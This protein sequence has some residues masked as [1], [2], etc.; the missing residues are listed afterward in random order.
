MLL[1]A[2]LPV[3]TPLSEH[4]AE[5]DLNVKRE[6]NGLREMLGSTNEGGSGLK[7]K[8]LQTVY[9]H[10]FHHQTRLISFLKKDTI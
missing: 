8:E 10:E 4:G 5:R 6:A 1:W 9:R 2:V 7:Q 3:L